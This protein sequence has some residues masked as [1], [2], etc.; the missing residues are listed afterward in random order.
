MDA[1]AAAGDDG[2]P[3]RHRRHGDSMSYS[4][5]YS[6]APFTGSVG[7][8]TTVL[9]TNLAV[10]DNGGDTGTVTQDGTAIEVS[11]GSVSLN[12]KITDGSRTSIYYPVGLAV[13][14]AAGGTRTSDNVFPPATVDPNDNTTIVLGDND[15]Q[16]GVYEFVVLFQAT[17][18]NFGVLDPRI[19]NDQ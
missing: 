6:I 7:T 3:D 1:G 2:K 8:V 11:G 13:Q 12:I 14:P 16:E 19:T 10:V 18:G 9:P 15:N 17:N 4:L 5:T